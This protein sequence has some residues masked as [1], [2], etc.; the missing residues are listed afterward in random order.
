MG[1]VE[2]W[3]DPQAPEPNS[4]VPACGVLATDDEGR[5][6][7]QRCDGFPAFGVR[8]VP[9][10]VQ[11]AA[12]GGCPHLYLLA[13]RGWTVPQDLAARQMTRLRDTAPD[14]RAGGRVCPLLRERDCP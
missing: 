5:V 13:V 3:N 4:L 6:L 14:S 1:R 7:L 8:S 10:A 11:G 12:L 9:A 2:Y